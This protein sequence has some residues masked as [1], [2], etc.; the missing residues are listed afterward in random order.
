MG[1]VAI[2][3]HEECF[4]EAIGWFCVSCLAICCSYDHQKIEKCTYT[5][6]LIILYWTVSLNLIR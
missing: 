4:S 3:M 1:A 5:T 6:I 2:K